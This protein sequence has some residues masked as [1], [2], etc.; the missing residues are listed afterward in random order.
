MFRGFVTELYP[1]IIIV[2]INDYFKY[3]QTFT[4]TLIQT[5]VVSIKR[6][7]ITFFYLHKNYIYM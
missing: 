1:Y 4:Y 2:F 5:F 6:S 3:S 7:E